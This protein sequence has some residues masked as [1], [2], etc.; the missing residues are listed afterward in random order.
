[1]KLRPVRRGVDHSPTSFIIRRSTRQRDVQPNANEPTHSARRGQRARKKI[2]DISN[3]RT[4]EGV[5][6]PRF[7]G[8]LS[9]E[10]SAI[11]PTL[12]LLGIR[13]FKQVKSDIFFHFAIWEKV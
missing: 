12:S 2:S 5:K 4:S 9:D 1:L 10:E 3:K 11:K 6:T 8:L 7:F 13:K